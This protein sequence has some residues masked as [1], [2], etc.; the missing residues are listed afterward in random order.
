MGEQANANLR[1]DQ[2]RIA[3]IAARARNGVIG[4]NGDLPWRL[5]GDLADFKRLTMGK[6]ILMGRKTWA[7][8]PRR[9]LPGR[10]NLVLTRQPEWWAVG[11]EAFVNLNAMLAR[12]RRLAG[13]GGEAMVIGGAALYA[14][15]L[16]LADRL[17]LTE[18]EAEVEGDALFP[19]I[20][21][22]AWREVE[23]T[24]FPADDTNAFARTLRVL[25]RAA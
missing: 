3:L 5:P 10:P 2:P 15:T 22:A 4:A 9:P 24:A 11:A 7:S 13:T 19:E 17:Y 12:G 21:P 25:D 14:D 1:A 20:D 23:T 8:L 18:V 16:G 6:P